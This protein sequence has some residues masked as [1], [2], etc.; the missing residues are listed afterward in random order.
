MFADLYA[1]PE[2]RALFADHHALQC[3]L[4]VE[5]ALARAQA[6]LGLVPHS[7][8]D[9]ITEAAS[10]ERIDIAA[11]AASTRI[12]G[13]PVVALTKEL[14]RAAGEA[15]AS[16][17]HVGA[18]TQDIL[19]TALV[20]QMR[21][22][23]ALIEHDLIALAH[24][25]YARAR[26][27]RSDAMAGRTHLQHA[28]P[29]TFGYKCAVWLT[30]LL[31]HLEALRR[32]REHTLHVQFGGAAG[33]LASLG[34]HGRKVTI[35]LARELGL[36]VPDISWHAE[37]TRLATIA[38]LL[39]ILCGSLATFATDII[40][41][42]QTEIGE[43]FE[44][45]EQ[46]RGSSST[47][48]QK[49]NPIASE[50]VIASARGAQALVPLMLGAMIGDHERSSGPWQSEALALPQIFMLTSGA[51]MHAVV[52]AQGMTV[53]TARMRQNLD[54]SGGLIL[55]EALSAALAQ[56]LGRAA[57]HELVERACAAA[58]AQGRTLIDVLANEPRVSDGL[59]RAS[60]DRLLDPANY[61]GDAPD[62]VNRV[63]ARAEHVLAGA[64]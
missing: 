61:L 63:L 21:A 27:H 16:H 20:L 53:D 49:R 1:N 60:L 55:A 14:A 2:M 8:A 17:I 24:A 43:V 35:E 23:L 64:R 11:I 30:P 12:V 33:T 15:A 26:T 42:M 39:G 62:A 40:L 36:G 10:V 9:A 6:R 59:D 25:L 31:D 44:P 48:P 4:D 3:M 54:L 50:Y 46:G 52:I 56:R 41:L 5:A 19:D 38:A 37:R 13:Y 29:I 58:I 7:A 45:Y 47:M 51:L 28:V 22:G 34:E 32:E 57:A 18:T